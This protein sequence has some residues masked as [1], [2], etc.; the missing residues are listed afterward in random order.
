[1]GGGGCGP[2]PP[3]PA[4][5]LAP[6]HWAK[7]ATESIHPMLQSDANQTSVNLGS[8]CQTW[9]TENCPIELQ[10]QTGQNRYKCLIQFTS[11]EKNFT[12][13]DKCVFRMPLLV[14]LGEEKQS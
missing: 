6:I 3:P 12:K 4:G 1:M 2:L 11:S 10:S 14:H 5:N 9:C 8:T 13:L 7:S